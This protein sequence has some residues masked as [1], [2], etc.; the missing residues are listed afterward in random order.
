MDYLYIPIDQINRSGYK[1][2]IQFL[3]KLSEYPKEKILPGIR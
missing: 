2:V 1:S 3:G